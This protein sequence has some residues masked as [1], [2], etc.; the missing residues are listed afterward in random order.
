M[1]TSRS[2]FYVKYSVIAKQDSAGTIGRLP[3]TI[4]NLAAERA[5]G[6]NELTGHF[7]TPHEVNSQL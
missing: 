5:R 1:L 6:R 2:H 4:I 7:L 3:E